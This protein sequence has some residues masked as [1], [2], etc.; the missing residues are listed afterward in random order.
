MSGES[1]AQREARQARNERKRDRQQQRKAQIDAIK[2]ASFPAGT[3]PRPRR[4]RR[5]LAV[6][7][8]Y[9]IKVTTQGAGN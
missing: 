9:G 1:A 3:Q 6:L 8:K 4:V 2:E 5:A 7:Q